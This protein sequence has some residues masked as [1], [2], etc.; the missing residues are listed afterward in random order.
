MIEDKSVSINHGNT[1]R[2]V[3]GFSVAGVS[4]LVIDLLVFNLLLWAW[5]N[6]SLANL[7]AGA[8]ALVTNFAINFRTF[9]GSTSDRTSWQATK[10]FSLVAGMSVLYIYALFEAFLLIAPESNEL[11]L[12]AVRVFLIGSSSIARFFLYRRWVF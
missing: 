4:A 6:P 9:R 8:T 10:R 3:L 2:Y 12:T 5:G 11:V 7:V 1:G